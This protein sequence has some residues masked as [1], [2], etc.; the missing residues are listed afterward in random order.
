MR[1]HHPLWVVQRLPLGAEHHE[2]VGVPA[3]QVARHDVVPEGWQEQP[4]TMHGG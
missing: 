1:A 2:G 4:G 3:G